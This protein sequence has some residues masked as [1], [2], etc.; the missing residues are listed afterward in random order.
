MEHASPETRFVLRFEL[1]LAMVR[2]GRGESVQHWFPNRLPRNSGADLFISLE[3][4]LPVF[5]VVLARAMVAVPLRLGSK[6]LPTYPHCT[7]A[8]TIY[9]RE[10]HVGRDAE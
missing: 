1:L 9:I 6:T 8:T 3:L 4:L 2:N 5:I 10:H 7:V